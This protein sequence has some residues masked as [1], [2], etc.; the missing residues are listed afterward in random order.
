MS[1]V[2]RSFVPVNLQAG[3]CPNPKR[4]F[5]GAA[6]EVYG[7]LTV[8][9][10]RHGG[11]VFPSVRNIAAHTKCW[12]NKSSKYSERQVKRILRTF[13]SLGVLGQYET[14]TIHRRSY[15]GWQF[16][17]HRLWAET[18]GD[19]CEFKY[20][21]EYADSCKGKCFQGFREQNVPADVTTDVPADVT[22]NQQN[23]PADVPNC[24]IGLAVTP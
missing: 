5:R 2:S 16:G 4:H 7:Y 9:A 18:L 22:K 24:Q 6:R 19:L 23:V 12:R 15:R 20:W 11:F 14:R 21:S 3:T 1:V 10:A 17:E 13:K 8:L